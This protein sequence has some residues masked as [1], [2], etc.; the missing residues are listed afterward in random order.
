VTG[1]EEISADHAVGL[2]FRSDHPLR[3]FAAFG[4][5]AEVLGFDSVGVFGDL[6]FP[7]PIGALLMLASATERVALGPICLNPVMLHPVEIAGQTALLDEA[8][9]GRAFLGLARGSWLGKVGLR[10]GA[11]PA[12]LAEAAEVV[13][14][15]LR[16]DRRGYSGARFELE[17][18]FALDPEPIRPAVPLL[19]GT[20]GPRTAA[21]AAG[22]ADEVK[23]GGCANPRMVQRMAEWLAAADRGARPAPPRIVAG[24]VTVVDTDRA[25]ARARA[26]REAAMYIDVVAALDPTVELPD[27]LPDRLASLLRAGDTTAAGDLIPDD[28]LDRFA[29]CGTPTDIV[30]HALALFD[31]GASRVEF[32]SPHGIDSLRGIELLGRKV[33]PA[34][35]AAR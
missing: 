27:G 1:G 12:M 30:N 24:A 19:V 6:G 10:A 9:G 22:W 5:A 29:I 13:G 16:G 8:S 33:L 21:S 28:L 17:P 11:G 26:R 32:G 2:G 3:R 25:T 15:L 18:G 31:S 7:P 34:L 14:H 4:A 35:R 20:W 23:L